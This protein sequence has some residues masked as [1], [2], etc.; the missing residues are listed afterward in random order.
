MTYLEQ[1]LFGA[2]PVKELKCS[3]CSEQR[4]ISGECSGGF[5]ACYV[6]FGVSVEFAIKT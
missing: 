6:N 3:A 5:V 2:C 1:M 4:G